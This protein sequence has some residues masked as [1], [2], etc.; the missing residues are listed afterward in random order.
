MSLNGH[1]RML[2][3]RWKDHYTNSYRITPQST[4]GQSPSELL[5][6]RRLTSVLDTAH[7][8]FCQPSRKEKTNSNARSF[9]LTDKLF[10]RNYS[11]QPLWIS[12][13]V[14]KVTGPL[15][16]HVETMNGTVL[17]RHVDQLRKRYTEDSE[18]DTLQED[19]DW[20][21]DFTPS[22]PTMPSAPPTPPPI[23]C[24]S[25]RSRATGDRGPYVNYVC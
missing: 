12:V 11:G 6:G 5:M 23:P 4:T 19:S 1:L 13:V 24:Q 17:K 8:D 18:P 9:K 25:T 2:L 16:Y 3:R 20:D 10:A 22:I 15:S 21:D 14:C 7:P